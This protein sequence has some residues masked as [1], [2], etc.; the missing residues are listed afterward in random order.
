MFCNALPHPSTL[1]KW[2]QGVSGKP[3]FSAEAKTALILKTQHM[4]SMDKTV[5]VCLMMDE[6][7]I[8]KHIEFDGKRFVSYVDFRADVKSDSL[9]EAKDALCLWL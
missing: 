3:G 6:M 8:R 5:V 4:A 7:S 9:P 2:Y 1:R